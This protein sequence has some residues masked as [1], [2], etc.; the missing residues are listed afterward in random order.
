MINQDPVSARYAEALFG[1]IKPSGRLAEA[2][3]EL[4]R[5]GALIRAHADLPQFLCNPGVEAEDK[6]GVLE[7]LLGGGW[8]GDVRAFVRLVL[9]M[10]RPEYLVEMAD[11]FQALVDEDAGLLR[12]TV[13]SAHP[14]S[15][16]ARERLTRQL[17]RLERRRIEMAEATDPELI[18]GIQVELDHRVLDGSVKT[19]LAELR[20]RLKSVRVH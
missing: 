2:A 3:Q 11:A 4:A 1:L 8:S 7:R 20:Q 17:E 10:G 15:A 9:S 19:K 5:V 14:L 12:V 16:A 18:G 6:L 13:R